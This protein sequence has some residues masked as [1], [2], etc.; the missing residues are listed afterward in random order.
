MGRIDRQFGGV[1]PPHPVA[2][3]NQQG[4]DHVGVLH[5]CGP[6]GTLDEAHH[7][8][9]NHLRGQQGSHQRPGNQGPAQL[10][11]HQTSLGPAQ[12]DPAFVLGHQ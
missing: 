3:E 8:I 2:V 9:V 5:Q 7:R 12:S 6:G 11:E 1:H 4:V 10:L